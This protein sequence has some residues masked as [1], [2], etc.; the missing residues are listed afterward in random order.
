[1]PGYRAVLV[2]NGDYYI[3]LRDRV[4][5]AREQRAD[6][7]VSVHADA[8]KSPHPSG[9][10]VYALSDRGATSESRPLAGG[11]GEPLGSDRRRRRLSPS[12]T[13]TTCSPTCCSTS[14]WTPTGPPAS[15]LAAQPGSPCSSSGVTSLHKK[16]VEQAGF[17]VSQ[18]ARRP[19]DPGGDR[20]HLQSRRRRA[21]STTADHQ[22]NGSPGRW[23]AP[24]ATHMEDNAPHRN[25]ARRRAASRAASGATPST[26]GDTLSQIAAR[27]GITTQPSA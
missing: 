16:R 25:S 22:E 18:G 17:A 11:E 26:N 8:F 20:V 7:F 1:M 12:A 9:A 23:P 21:G 15:R 3:A 24:S 14:P 13:R 5:I 27:Y 4:R 10:S 19:V 6:L 2:R